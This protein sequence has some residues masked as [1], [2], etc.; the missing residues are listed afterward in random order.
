MIGVTSNQGSLFCV[1]VWR[2]VVDGR[3]TTQE[4]SARLV[5]VRT[6]MD[7]TVLVSCPSVYSLPS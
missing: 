1:Q 4:Y 2:G 3:G 6:K 7:V 5:T